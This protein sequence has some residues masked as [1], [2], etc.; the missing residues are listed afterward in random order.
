M[1][2][3]LHSQFLF[4]LTKITIFVGRFNPWANQFH[5]A[6]RAVFEVILFLSA[7]VV[8]EIKILKIF[9]AAVAEEGIGLHL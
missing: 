4:F 3:I 9:L 8:G 6:Y 5:W 2:M 1:K 7:Y